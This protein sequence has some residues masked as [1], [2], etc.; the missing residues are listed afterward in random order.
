MLY[1]IDSG[2]KIT[3]IPYLQDYKRWRSRLTDT[4]YDAI[5]KE[6]MFQIS[7]S[8][9]KTS[10]WIPGSDWTGTVYQPIYD[11]ACDQDVNASA[12]FFGLIV[13]HVFMEHDEWWSFGRFQLGN[14]PI[15]GLT[16]FR[17]DDPN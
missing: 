4:E 6:L 11:K 14:I 12:K 10:S 5:Y 3:R 8:K 7:G 1:S 13:W 17:I 9:I 2:K 15:D 16:Y